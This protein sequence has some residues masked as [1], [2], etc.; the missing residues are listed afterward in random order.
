MENYSIQ[1]KQKSDNI[2]FQRAL[3]AKILLA[4]VLLHFLFCQYA[5]RSSKSSK[6]NASVLS[7][8]WISYAA[9]QFSFQHAWVWFAPDLD[10]DGIALLWSL[11]VKSGTPS[12]F[13]H[14]NDQVINKLKENSAL[15]LGNCYLPAFC[16]SSLNPPRS[17][18]YQ[19]LSMQSLSV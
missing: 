2:K 18:E 13:R 7:S 11:Q 1:L 16:F 9:D 17:C 4:P 3:R 5:L 19:S 12:E 10:A 8:F 14:L 15:Y 6:R